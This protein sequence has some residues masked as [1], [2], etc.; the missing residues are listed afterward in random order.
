VK[1]RP[2]EGLGNSPQE[3]TAPEKNLK[4]A[5]GRATSGSLDER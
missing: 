3:T 5:V 1:I 2:V 4:L